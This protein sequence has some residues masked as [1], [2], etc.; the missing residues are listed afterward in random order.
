MLSAG[1]YMPPN[2]FTQVIYALAELFLRVYQSLIHRINP[3]AQTGP[4]PIPTIFAHSISAYRCQ[5]HL[6][7]PIYSYGKLSCLD[8]ELPAPLRPLIL[9]ISPSDRYSVTFLPISDIQFP[10]SLHS[11]IYAS[12]ALHSY[13][14]MPPLPPMFLPFFSDDP[15]DP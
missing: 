13:I 11:G 15:D 12:Y 10:Q 2:I 7:T 14:F 8:P 3:I 1:L 5:N 6:Y 9:T 4:L